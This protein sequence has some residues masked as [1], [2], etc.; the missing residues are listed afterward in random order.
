MNSSC[1]DL[2][3]LDLHESHQIVA[4]ELVLSPIRLDSRLIHDEQVLVV[5]LDTGI[6]S[7]A[8][9]HHVVLKDSLRAKEDIVRD[10]RR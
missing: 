8:T 2:L 4:E 6:V 7:D 1:D 3:V 5:E 10:S 9:H